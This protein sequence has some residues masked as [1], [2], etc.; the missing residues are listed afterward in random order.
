MERN[1][2]FN[3]V[4]R[5]LSAA[6]DRLAKRMEEGVGPIDGVE[7][8]F[9]A[10]SSA[11]EG[12]EARLAGAREQ[13]DRGLE[14]VVAMGRETV[15]AGRV[16]AEASAALQAQAAGLE[17]A[18]A[19]IERAEIAAEA[20]EA[21]PVRISEALGDVEEQVRSVI[22]RATAAMERVE[23]A[24]AAP[25]PAEPLNDEASLVQPYVPPVHTLHERPPA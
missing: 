3:T 23:A 18:V 8:R 1:T 20:M 19:A 21:Q 12:L 6:V 9:A 7:Q 14:T 24:N 2:E 10:L 22:D 17:R 4:G 5:R 25:P 16:A 13:L 15:D 11:A